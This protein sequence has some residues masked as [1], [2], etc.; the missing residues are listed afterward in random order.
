[1]AD[2]RQTTSYGPVL[3]EAP[4]GNAEVAQSRKVHPPMNGPVQT[5]L[6]EASQTGQTPILDD[7]GVVE[8]VSREVV[9]LAESPLAPL[10][11]AALAAAIKRA[12]NAWEST[13][14]A[15]AEQLNDQVS[16]LAL[17]DTL[18]ELLETPE[19]ARTSARQL[20]DAL[21]ANHQE[22]VR[23][24]PHLA[25]VRLEGALRVALAR[26]VPPYLVLDRLA[27][28]DQDDP[29]EF[30]EI[31]PRLIGIALDRWDSDA[32][33]TEPLITTLVG[34]RGVPAAAAGAM[35]E[36]AC[37]QLR[38]ALRQSNP[39]D[40]PKALRLR[41][42]GSPRPPQSTSPATTRPSTPRCA[43]PSLHLAQANDVGFMR[44]PRPSTM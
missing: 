26:A 42:R 8:E 27:N 32:T 39:N 31:L 14:A 9:G 3:P 5:A 6:V 15:F 24:H 35:Y 13:V 7:L 11:A 21:L 20:H 40:A 12:P 16:I 22:T 33:L 37:Q 1:M 30:L 28:F 36:L 2:C 34:L 23:Q 10:A 41:A 38:E 4:C 43:R 19:A 18:D 25:A 17:A 29:D 44:S